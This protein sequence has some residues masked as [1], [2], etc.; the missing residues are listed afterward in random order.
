MKLIMISVHDSA[1][2]AWMTP[3]FFQTVP[4]AL[5]S[6]TD[7]VNESGS[8]YAK[9]PEDYALFQVGSFDPETGVVSTCDPPQSLG[10]AINY[11]VPKE[12][13]LMREARS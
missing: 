8:D 10:L 3:M 9:H 13:K 6:F 7:A 4:Q 5:R 2:E 11:I 12:P 1:S